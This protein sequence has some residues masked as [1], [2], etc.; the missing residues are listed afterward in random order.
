MFFFLR[1]RPDLDGS[2]C[3]RKA[4]ASCRS[5]LDQSVPPLTPPS[6]DVG[7]PGLLL[8]SYRTKIERGQNTRSITEAVAK[9][10]QSLIDQPSAMPANGLDAPR[11]S[12]MKKSWA[13]CTCTVYLLPFLQ[14][15]FEFVKL[16]AR[17]C[18][19]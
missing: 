1:A 14:T 4:P 11:G 9:C 15:G 16:P 6:N 2:N 18:T 3:P 5:F 10:N 7:V 19:Q 12:K 17:S 8:S 13:V